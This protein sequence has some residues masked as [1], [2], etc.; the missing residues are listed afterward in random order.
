[1]PNMIEAMRLAKLA[2]PIFTKYEELN[3][4]NWFVRLVEDQ[5]ES[6]PAR[7][8]GTIEQRNPEYEEPLKIIKSASTVLDLFNNLIQGAEEYE[9]MIATPPEM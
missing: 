7:W 1:M 4:R 6:G 2:Y 8:V 5:G 3:E 9:K